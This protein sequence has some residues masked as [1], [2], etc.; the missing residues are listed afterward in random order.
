VYFIIGVEIKYKSGVGGWLM[1]GNIPSWAG[2][3]SGCFL[4]LFLQAALF[5]IT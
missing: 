3:A 4:Q 1:S 5:Y 2:E